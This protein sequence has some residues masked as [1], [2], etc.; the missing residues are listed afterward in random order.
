MPAVRK[1]RTMK[2]MLSLLSPLYAAVFLFRV[3]LF[4]HMAA[5]LAT[6]YFEIPS[7]KQISLLSLNSTWLQFSEHEQNGNRFL[8]NLLHKWLPA[9]SYLKPWEPDLPC[10]YFSQHCCLPS[11]PKNGPW[12]PVLMPAYCDFLATKQFQGPMRHIVSVTTAMAPLLVLSTFIYFPGA[13][14]LKKNDKINLRVER[15][16]FVSEFKV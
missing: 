3:D 1:K 15:F 5:S 12:S 2:P 4:S 14:T 6:H 16:I 10:V 8:A 7:I 9:Q 13:V 11:S